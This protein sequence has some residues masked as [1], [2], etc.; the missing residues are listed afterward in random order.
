M[1]LT[2]SLKTG[3]FGHDGMTDWLTD[4]RTDLD[5]VTRGLYLDY[6]WPQSILTFTMWP[7]ACTLTICEYRVY[8]PWPCDQRSVP[9][10]HVSTEYTDLDHFCTLIIY[11]SK[12][13]LNLTLWPEACTLPIYVSTEYWPWPCDLWPVAWAAPAGSWGASWW[14]RTAGRPPRPPVSTLSSRRKSARLRHKVQAEQDYGAFARL[15]M[16]SLLS[17]TVKKVRNFPVFSLDVTGRE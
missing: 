3:G 12:S 10:L 4:S 7:D 16:V 6:M 2:M 11:M 14:R 5:H 9:W 17:C 8:W 15:S 13:I 1:F